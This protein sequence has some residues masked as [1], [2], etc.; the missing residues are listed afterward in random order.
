MGVIAISG[1]A[2]SGKTTI[3]KLLAWRLGYRTVSIGELFR[4]AARERGV[5]LIELHK[6]AESDHSIDKMVDSYTLEEA[7]K[8]NIVIEGHLVAWVL[9]GIAD[10]KIYLKA[11][12]E[13]RANRLAARDGRSISDA[14]IEIRSRE[15]SNRKRYKEIYGFDVRDLSIFDLVI[16]T[17][18]IDPPNVLDVIMEYVKQLIRYPAPL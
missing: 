13:V 15:E 1:E 11:S 4:R 16:D 2:A 6:L 17:T 3:A 7:K 9:R 8:G 14:L 10:V 18:R 12:E 5:S